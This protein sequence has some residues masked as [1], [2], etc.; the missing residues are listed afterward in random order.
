MKPTPKFMRLRRGPHRYDPFRAGVANNLARWMIWIQGGRCAYC[1]CLHPRDYTLDHLIPLSRGGTREIEN[2]IGA[3]R[4]CNTAKGAS[5][6][7]HFL[8]RMRHRYGRRWSFG[9]ASHFV[10]DRPAY[11][12]AAA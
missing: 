8:L 2:L 3:C 6:P 12:Q 11:P 4:A 10:G 7:L 5:T 9:W 1:G